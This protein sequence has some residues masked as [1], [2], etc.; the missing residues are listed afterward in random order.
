MGRKAL[1]PDHGMLFVFDQAAAQCFW[2]KNT[3]LPLSIAFITTGGSILSIA[4]ME[5][6][7]EE[8]HCQ[9]GPIRYALEMQKG[10]FQRDRK[11]VGKGKSVAVRVD[12]GGG[13]IS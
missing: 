8:V 3:Q 2:M 13:R 10:W 1:A 5:P 4:M 11:S 9:A 12:L 7:S 6:F